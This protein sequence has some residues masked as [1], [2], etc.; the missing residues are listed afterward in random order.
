VS[1]SDCGWPKNELHWRGIDNSIV[2]IA[3][4]RT[5][6]LAI[7]DGVVGMEGDGPLNGSPRCTGVVVMGADLPAVDATWRRLM[8]LDPEKVLYLALAAP[9]KLG[10]IA[11]GQIRQLGEAVASRAQPFDTVEHFRPLWMGRGA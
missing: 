2:D 9:K 7:V 3:L 1:S 5:P 6:D 4:T 10:A 11:E 8:Q